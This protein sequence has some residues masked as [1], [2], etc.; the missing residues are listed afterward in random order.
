MAIARVSDKGQITL[1]ADMRRQLGI[2]PKS[3]VEVAVRGKEVVIRPVGSLTELSGVFQEYA[4]GKPTDWETIR[5]E[6][7]RLV[8]EEVAREGLK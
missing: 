1:P 4:E 3:R 2:E 6:T 8:A 7:E 5:T